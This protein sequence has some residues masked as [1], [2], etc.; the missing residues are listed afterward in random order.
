MSGLTVLLFSIGLLLVVSVAYLILG[1][2]ADSRSADA[3]KRRQRA[4]DAFAAVLFAEDPKALVS[5]PVRRS[6]E[7]DTLVEVVSTLPVQLGI[8]GRDRLRSVLETPRTLRT[9]QRL[10]RSRRW[11]SR[12]D[13]ARL[14]ALMGTEEDRN[15]LLADRHWAVR[16]VAVSALSQHQ[17]AGHAEEVAGLLLDD[18][19]AVRI[20]AAEALPAA[21]VDAVLPLNVILQ[22]TSPDR[23]AALR[24]AS[25]LTDR[26]LIGAL[27]RHAHC[28]HVGNRV[29]ATTA[30][31]RQSPV[32]IESVLLEQLK[33]PAPSVRAAAADGLGRI[34]S[35]MVYG[36]LREV[37][38]DSSWMVRRAA[39]QSLASSSAAGGMLVRQHHQR[40]TELPAAGQLRRKVPL[41]VAADE[42]SR[43][44]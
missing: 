12:I 37:L 33:D 4:V 2:A 25:R 18:K 9:F 14:C 39:E 8:D 16:V 40:R 44:L 32:E 11:R 10:A 13:A 21:G 31:A 23:E 30:L 1:A 15:A 7:R 27:I 20:A 24:A 42:R 35:P 6:V 38:T 28:D 36:A 5:F 26:L 22:Q 17:V 29:L 41:P 34:G 3:L 19:P 43:L